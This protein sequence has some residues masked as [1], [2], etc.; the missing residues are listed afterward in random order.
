MREDDRISP[1]DFYSATKAAGEFVL[2]AACGEHGMTGVVLRPGPVVGKPAF[3]GGSFRGFNPIAAIVK[4]A[5]RGEEIALPPGG[6]RQYTSARDLAKVVRVLEF[7]RN[8]SDTY[9]CMDRR[10]TAWEE[11]ARMVV[12][13]TGSSSRFSKVAAEEEETKPHFD[14]RR[15]DALL[16]FRM[17]S[18]KAL[19]GSIRELVR[20]ARSY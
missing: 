8:P 4:A 14:T 1:V 6:G 11:V 20:K 9:L 19:A 7:A 5:L 15:V 13:M 12:E 10:V 2:R 16:A 3:S 18:S 17:N